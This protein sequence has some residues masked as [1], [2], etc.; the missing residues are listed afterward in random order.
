MRN[1]PF[2]QEVTPRG[3]SHRVTGVT[4]CKTPE[5]SR[6][7]GG[8]TWQRE[9]HVQK[10]GRGR[11]NRLWGGLASGGG[12]KSRSKYRGHPKVATK[13]WHG[14][15]F[16]EVKVTQVGVARKGQEVLDPGTVALPLTGL[17]MH[18]LRRSSVPLRGCLLHG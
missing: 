18:S 3:S 7:Y 13:M 15:Q 8:F 17:T 16:Q 4:C 2:T 10:P 12:K 6:L 5:G 11:T 14:L 1:Q 9:W